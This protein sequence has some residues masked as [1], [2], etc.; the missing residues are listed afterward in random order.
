MPNPD[1]ASIE[2][3][4]RDIVRDLFRAGDFESL[5]VK[6]VRSQAEE[7]LGLDA[8]WF[9]GH[10][11]WKDRSAKCIHEEAVRSHEHAGPDEAD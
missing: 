1:G 3:T 5:T 2:S 11:E 4:V 7:A 9:N 8:G 10:A 6:R